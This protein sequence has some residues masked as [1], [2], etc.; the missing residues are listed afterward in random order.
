MLP[1]ARFPSRTS[2]GSA[3]RFSVWSFVEGFALWEHRDRV[4]ATPAA[5]MGVSFRNQPVYS[6]SIAHV[7]P[8]GVPPV[9]RN[10]GATTNEPAS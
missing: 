4:D 7:S 8:T 9:V 5:R 6:S 2:F 1:D 3:P 10:S